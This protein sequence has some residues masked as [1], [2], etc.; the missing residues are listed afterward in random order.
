M[1]NDKLRERVLEL[2]NYDPEAGVFARRDRRGGR[3]AGTEA[4]TLCHG[5]IR[6]RIDGKY[7]RAH[8]LAFLV[9][10]GF[11][12]K[13]ID[14]I[15]LV[16]NDNR[17]ENLR[18]AT[19]QENSRNTGKY[20]NNKSGFKGVHLQKSSGKWQAKAQAENGKQK[21][22]G[23]FPT[24]ESASAAYNDFARKLHGDF[25]RPQVCS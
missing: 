19:R 2:F 3:P 16:R 21:H 4:G 8:R 6:I 15:S 1:E 14:H 18:E 7:H 10:H 12:P 11:I 9:V 25:Y 24:P 17:I 22:L 5:Y 23:Y 13:E 20:S